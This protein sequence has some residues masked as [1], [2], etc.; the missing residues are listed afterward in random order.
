[1]NTV[2]RHNSALTG[3]DKIAY[4]TH[5]PF[6]NWT[7][8]SFFDAHSVED[9]R[10]IIFMSLFPT[11]TGVLFGAALIVFIVSLALRPLKSLADS[12]KEVAGGNMAVAFK[13]NSNDEISQVGNA[14][15]EIVRVL[16]ILRS[17]FKK[18]ENAMVGGD[19]EYNLIDSRLGGVY[20]SMMLSI[21]NIVEHM[22]QS[23]LVAENASKAKSDFLSKMSHEIRTPMNAILGMSELILREDITP[24]AREHAQTI[25]Q[26]G[27]H[28]LSIINDILDLSKVES[29]KLEIVNSEYLFHSTIQDVVSIV[30]MRM[31]DPNI[32]FAVYVQ[33]T[34]PNELH[35][36]EVRVRQ[37]LLNLLTNALKYTKQGH[38]TLDVTGEVVGNDTT[39]LTMK[40]KDTGIGIKEEDMGKLFGEFSQFDLQKN[41]GVEGTGLGLAITLNL[42][43]LMGGEIKVSSEYGVGSEFIVTLPQKMHTRYHGQ[44]AVAPAFAEASVL[45]Y[46]RTTLYNDYIARSLG[47][48]AVAYHIATD[49]AE[50]QSALAQREWEYIFAE[51][52]LTYPALEVAGESKVVMLVDSYDSSYKPRDGQNFSLLIMPAYFLSIASVLSGESAL[53]T[54][55]SEMRE[56]FTA[57]EARILLVDDIET[58]LKV[59]EG[60]LKPYGLEVTLCTGGKEA[61]EA[62]LRTEYDLVL[63]DHMMPEMDGVEAVKI[64]RSLGGRH[65]KLPIVALTANAIVGA[66]EMFLQNGFDDFL[67]KP[68][69]V[70]K[71][72]ATLAKWIPEEKQIYSGEAAATTEEPVEIEIAGINTAQGL[73]YSGGSAAAYLSTLGVF[74][75]DGT[76]KISQLNDCVETHDVVLYTTYVHAL[77]SAG[78]NI[79]A[80]ELSAQ[81]GRLEEAG[82]KHDWGF[83][84]QNHAA[85]VDALAAL[86]QGI[87]EVLAANAEAPDDSPVDTAALKELF[88]KLTPALQTYDITVIDEV[89]G[90][91]QKFKNTTVGEEIQG[92]LDN[93]LVGMYPDAET[94][95][96]E[97]VEKL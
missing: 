12:A 31:A 80:A 21:S 29:G 73:R 50:L 97:M 77:K 71:L 91:L 76:S 27:D 60:L 4:V 2:F 10:R 30:K 86:L 3:I 51:G 22:Q 93:I 82:M 35:G 34:I 7:I 38:F 68:I 95:I 88:A 83:I 8:V 66:R 72:N 56:Q 40:I 23:K 16:N 57:P 17:N 42:V 74:H 61:I 79:G 92:I 1:M 90:E 49:E 52:D 84:K 78:A 81:A 87:G 39:L 15:I 43:K 54:S 33:N 45:L 37:V 25:K 14:F 94:L 70:W 6:L 36:D 5:D 69:E 20:D 26:S 55:E 13:V 58:N 96:N 9:V 48:M 64:I 28:L 24:I 85:V 47:D 63:M 11:V 41:K 67:S 44:D 53:S 89:S 32:H 65:A 62:V 18:A 19:A 46:C 75:K 59:G